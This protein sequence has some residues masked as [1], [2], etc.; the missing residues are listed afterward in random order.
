MMFFDTLLP[1]VNNVARKQDLASS[2]YRFYVARKKRVL[3]L[4]IINS[5]VELDEFWWRVASPC[6]RLTGERSNE[7]AHVVSGRRNVRGVAERLQRDAQLANDRPIMV[8]A[9]TLRQHGLRSS[10]ALPRWWLHGSPIRRQRTAC[11]GTRFDQ[12]APDRSRR[13]SLGIENVRGAV[14]HGWTQIM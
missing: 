7:E 8:P 12:L 11:A 13:A 2:F 4:H 6:T 1:V 3:R 9:G 5:D 10:D 14:H